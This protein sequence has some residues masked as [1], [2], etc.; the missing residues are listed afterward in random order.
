M[1]AHKRPDEKPRFFVL[2]CL[3]FGTLLVLFFSAI[4]WGVMEEG[5]S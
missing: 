5:L 1:I 2:A 3:G 4:G